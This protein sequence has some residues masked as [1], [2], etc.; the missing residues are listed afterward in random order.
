M[1]QKVYFAHPINT[2]GT[3]LEKFAL[4]YFSINY[5][6]WEIIN[7]NLLE[8]QEGYK[9]DGMD[10]F[11]GV[12][13]SCDKLV[14]IGFGDNSIGAGIAKEMNWMKEKGGGCLF[15]SFIQRIR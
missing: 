2:Y 15:H 8:H 6:H 5:P 13:L 11:K 4:E 14:A 3:I 9:S 7:P 1:K 12:V 10:Y